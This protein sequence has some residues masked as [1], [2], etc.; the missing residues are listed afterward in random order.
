L[1]E[2]IIE[3]GEDSARRKIINTPVQATASDIIL[4][5][6]RTALKEISKRKL[7]TRWLFGIYDAAMFDIYP[8]EEKELAECLQLGFLSV[9][10]S[11]LGKLPLYKKLPFVGDLIIG[12]TWAHCEKTNEAFA[13]DRKFEMSTHAA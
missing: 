12:E 8:G 5:I 4:I 1:L 6:L 11:P 9:V 10:K 7:K 13:P 2:L 3:E